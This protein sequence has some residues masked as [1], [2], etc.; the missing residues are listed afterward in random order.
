MLGVLPLISG[1]KL[2]T[3]FLVLG[4]PIVDGL[5]VA[6]G[7]IVR[8]QNP[9]TTP[10]K[11]HLHHRF[12]AA[13]FSARQAILAMYLIAVAFGWVALRS[14]TDQKLIAAGI[15]VLSLT[16]LIILLSIV[17]KIRKSKKIKA[18]SL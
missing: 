16:A 5:V 10:D 14:S 2:A 9:L 6:I 18:E 8:H 3:V 7:R 13:G 11:T 4:F 12:L 1:G 15:L 17:S